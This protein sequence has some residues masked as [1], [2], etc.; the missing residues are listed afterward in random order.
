MPSEASRAAIRI[1]ANYTRIITGI[2]LSLALVPLLLQV[3]GSEGW[4]LI[5]FLGSTIGI[6]AMVQNIAGLSMI[7]EL[8][9]AHHSGN[10]DHFRSVYNASLAISLVLALVALIAFGIL[11]LV[12]PVLEIP[13]DLVDAARWLVLAR[14]AQTV[15][16]LLTAAPFNM[17][18]V[19]ERMVAFNIWL[20]VNR[21]CFVIAAVWLLILPSIDDPGRAVTHYAIL[22]SGLTIL[23]L[24]AASVMMVVIDRRLIPAPSTITRDATKTVLKIGGWNAGAT[25]VTMLYLRLG[26]LFMNLTFGLAGNFIFGVANRVADALRRLTVGMTE[27]LDAVSTRL[28]TTAK[29][30]AVRALMHH[31]TRLHGLVAFPMTVLVV[32]LSEPLL[33]LWIANQLDNPEQVMPQVI[34]LT[35]ILAIGITARAISDGWTRILYGAGHVRRYAPLIITGGFVYPLLVWLLLLVMPDASR[36]TAICWAYSILMV[37]VHGCL[38]PIIGARVLQVSSGQFFVPLLRPM[39]IAVI[40]WPILL[41]ARGREGQWEL[42]WLLGAGGVYGLVYFGLCVAFVIEPAERQRVLKATMR[43]LPF[44]RP[45]RTDDMR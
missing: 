30:G 45:G 27:G 14:G 22:S 40:C 20:T 6:P 24:L 2:V 15:V 3:A 35:R 41:A 11:W 9:V 1:G 37:T 21:S 43:R 44:R 39:I 4:A 36:Y 33:R 18:K 42:L 29:A 26:D 7:R 28:S 31:S 23:A 17:Y 38:L 12:V 16:V 19:T 10:L 8:G 5:A 34:V 32:A 13:A 25:T